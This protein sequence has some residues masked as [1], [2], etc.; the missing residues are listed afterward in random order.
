M[1]RTYVT[2]IAVMAVGIYFISCS[3]DGG[4]SGSNSLD[5]STVTNK[6]FN[7]N[8]NPIIQSFCNVV[9]CHAAGSNNGPGALTNYTEVFNARG[10]IRTAVANG[11]MPQGNSLTT[12]Q[13][14]SIVCWI[15]GGAPDN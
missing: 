10:L 12:A 5:C 14:N 8:I 9:N 4:G 11:T 15:D 2:V 13:K 6:A 1:K 7:A 3:K